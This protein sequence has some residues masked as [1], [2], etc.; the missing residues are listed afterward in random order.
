MIKL[1]NISK[2]FTT[3]D[4]IE[5]ALNGVDMDVKENTIHGVIGP[6]GAGKSTLIRIINQ[7]EAHDEGTLLSLIH[8]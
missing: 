4:G 3:K 1:T 2:S 6:S 5:H 7:L 8:I